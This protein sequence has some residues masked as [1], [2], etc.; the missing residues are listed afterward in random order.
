MSPALLLTALAPDVIFSILACCDVSSVVSAGQTCRYLRNMAFQRSVWLGLLENLRRKSILARTCNLN[1]LST[2]EMIGVVRRVITGPQTWNPGQLESEPSLSDPGNPAFPPS[3][4]M[5]KLLPSERYVL[6]TDWATLEC[7]DVGDDKLVWRYTSAIDPEH[8]RIVEFAAEETGIESAIIMICVRTHL[9]NGERLNYVEIVR[10]DLQNGTLD[11]L[12]AARAPDSGFSNPFYHPVISGALAAVK[13]INAGRDTY[14]IIN[15]KAR[16]HL[17][18]HVLPGTTLQVLLILEHMRLMTCPIPRQEQIH[19]ISNKTL[20]AYWAPII[21]IDHAA[22]FS[23]V[24]VEDIPKRSTFEHTDGQPFHKMYVHQNPL[25]DDDYRVW[26]R[27]TKYTANLSCYRLS[28]PTHG[29]PRW[30]LQSRSVVSGAMA[31]P[32]SY[33]GHSLGYCRASGWT[34]ISPRWSKECRGAQL[35]F[36]KAEHADLSPYSGPLIYST[37]STVVIQYYR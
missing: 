28:I 10:M 20:D 2:T 37:G 14:M 1:I 33:S 11:S 9:P 31:H 21:G 25:Q 26:I 16:S 35:S 5:A 12:L 19:L 34:V 23:P 17:I 8:V 7:W 18:L 24:F 32:V 13:M 4:Y 6:W 27:G 3:A 36:S 22:G 15:W 30:Q 29:Q